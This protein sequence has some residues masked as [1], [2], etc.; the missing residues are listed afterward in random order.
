MPSFLLVNDGVINKKHLKDHLQL[1][2][3]KTEL[4][5]LCGFGDLLLIKNIPTD[6]L[7][8][9]QLIRSTGPDSGI[10]QRQCRYATLK[11]D[12]PNFRRLFKSN[13]RR[14]RSHLISY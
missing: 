12:L 2:Q 10:R 13:M 7:K 1:L 14:Q 5:R 8:T 4:L 11:K 9:S 3:P 6:K